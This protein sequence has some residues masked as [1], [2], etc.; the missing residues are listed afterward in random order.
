MIEGLLTLLRPASWQVLLRDLVDVAI[1]AYAIYRLLLLL[2]GTRAMQ[3]STGLA[4][5]VVVY[6]FAQRAG[7]T[8]THT[9][10]DK[11]LGSFFL[12]V[13]VLFQGD[14]RRALMRVGTRPWFANFRKRE[15]YAAL[16]EVI[17]A[18]VKL[19]HRRIGAL[20]VFE[21]D[22]LLD[23]FVQQG[24]VL[25]AMVSAELIYTVFVPGYENPLHD[26]AVVIRDAK[27]WR[28]GGFLPLTANV[29]LDRSLGTRHRAAIGI[30]DETDA[31]VV[32]VSEESG[33]ISLC[34]NGNLVRGLDAHSL[35]HALYGLFYPKSLASRLLEK[36]AS[37][38]RE[39]RGDRASVPPRE[40]RKS[41]GQR[42][43]SSGA[44]TPATSSSRPAIE[45]DP[46]ESESRSGPD[47]TARRRAAEKE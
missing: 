2:R 11:V 4:V 40:A 18:C 26:G 24:T 1:V 21:R 38:K 27:V 7:L 34:F 31:V 25:D 14:I 3:V 39:E 5:V 41:A 30:T 6:F 15:E 46:S 19:A 20:V 45:R 32:I 35:R 43:T 22:G 44:P 9:L 37:R 17:E 28:A 10:L 42:A 13:I 8:T 33:Q 29:S 36:R 23:E 47:S 16:E 12:V